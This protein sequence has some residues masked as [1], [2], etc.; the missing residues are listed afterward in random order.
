LPRHLR[1]AGGSFYKVTDDLSSN[2]K[3]LEKKPET[4]KEKMEARIDSASRA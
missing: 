3:T 1:P 2:L 4:W